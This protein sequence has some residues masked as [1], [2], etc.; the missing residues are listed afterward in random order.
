MVF[1]EVPYRSAGV[2]VVAGV[3]NKVSGEVMEAVGPG[4]AAVVDGDEGDLIGI[5]G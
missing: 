3:S 1:E 5:G 2:E 4:M